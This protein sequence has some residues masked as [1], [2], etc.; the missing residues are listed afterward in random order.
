MFFL[1]FLFKKEKPLFF[2]IGFSVIFSLSSKLLII[3]LLLEAKSGFKKFK[4]LLN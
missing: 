1:F 4:L 3:L 2:S